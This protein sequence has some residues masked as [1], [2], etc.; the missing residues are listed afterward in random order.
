MTSPESPPPMRMLT[1]PLVMIA[2]AIFWLGSGLFLHE[3]KSDT[4]AYMFF[5]GITAFIVFLVGLRM[6]IMDRNRPD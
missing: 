3:R 6:T 5:G 4:E 2:A 1:G